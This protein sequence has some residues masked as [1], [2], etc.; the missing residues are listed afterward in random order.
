MYSVQFRRDDI[1]TRMIQEF[2]VDQNLKDNSYKINLIGLKM[3]VIDDAFKVECKYDKLLN[4][5]YPLLNR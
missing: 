2:R 1:G 3:L 4:E 5:S